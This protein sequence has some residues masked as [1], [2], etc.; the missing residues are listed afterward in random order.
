VPSL[1]SDVHGAARS[2]HETYNGCVLPKETNI[3]QVWAAETGIQ[4]T[5]TNRLWLRPT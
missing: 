1:I 3:L 4:Q 5:D 2:T